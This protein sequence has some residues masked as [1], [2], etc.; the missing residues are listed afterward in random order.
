MIRY[1]F[2]AMRSGAPYKVLKVP[3]DTTPQIRFTGNAEVKSTITLTIE[4]DAD[5]NWLTDMLSVVRVDNAD[6][7]P[8]GLFNITTCPRSLDENGSETQ[9]LTGYDQ[10][11]SLR[12]L[13]V[14]ERSLTIRAG[15]RYT[16]AIREQLLASGINVVSII[17]TNEV[18]M[19]DHAWET[20]HDPL[21]GG[22]CP[23]GGDQ[24]PGYLF[25]RQRRGGC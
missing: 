23:A 16:T 6:R 10:G 5:V 3:A 25:R 14:L 17:D 7:V 15:T 12:N 4:P 22:V 9:E 21:C 19:T 13:S 20:G 24:L 8:L 2:I 1:E 11:Y 18:L